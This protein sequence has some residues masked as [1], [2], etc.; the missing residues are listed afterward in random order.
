M[1]KYFLTLLFWGAVWGICEATAGYALHLAAV[2]LP[3]LPGALMFP[4][5]FLCMHRAQAATG[6]VKAPLYIA[7]IAASLKLAD[8]LVPGHDLIRVLNPAASIVLEGL[9][10][11]VVLALRKAPASV[12]GYPYAL[13]MG[14]LW[15]A[16]FSCHLYLISLFGL[17]AALV[18]SGAPILLRFVLLES[19]VNSLVIYAGLRLELR[20][21]TRKP[22]EIR[23]AAAWTACLVAL[24]LQVLL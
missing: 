6:E 12:A 22:W 3:G 10:V 19:F 15:R 23:P 4:I 5:G 20:L 24:G 9:A 18:T 7:F 21:P 14:V 8:F 13:A 16:L 2:A 11:T 17:P 1:R